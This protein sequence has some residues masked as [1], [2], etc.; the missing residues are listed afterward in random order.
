MRIVSALPPFFL[1]VLCG[2]G[3]GGCGRKGPPLAPLVFLPAPVGELTTKRLGSDA[4]L[5]FTI[6]TTNSD[7][8]NP[9]DLDRIEVYA[10]T[11]P[12]PTPADYV[13]YGTLIARIQIR[14]PRELTGAT[15]AEGAAAANGGV[16]PAATPMPEQ[17][18]VISVVE[19]L[20]EEH[21]VLGPLPFKQT[22]GTAPIVES[23]ETEGTVNLPLPIIRYYAVVG[24]S[25]SRNRRGAFA[26]PLGIPLVDPLAAP[27]DVKASYS[28]TAITLTWPETPGQFNVYDVDASGAQGTGGP[29]GAGGAGGAQG[30]ARIGRPVAP[31]NTA[32]LATPEFADPRLEFGTERCYAVRTVLTVG[33][34]AVESEPSPRVCVRPIDTFA[35]SAPRTLASVSSENVV[36][37]IWEPNIEKDLG[38]YR[39]LRGEGPDA[40]LAPLTPSPIQETTYRD[41]T[42]ESGRTYTYAVEAVDTATPPNVS[43]PSNR[44]TETIR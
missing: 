4:V 11:G 13:R 26:G 32:A 1:C 35:P 20:T 37:L 40:T 3:H 2:L 44:V 42:V 28:E 21:K 18:A 5:Q 39:V 7:L 23:L 17:G 33:A 25:R 16:D 27:E 9:A 6:P 43:E 10:H 24:V 41:E 14:D 15:G 31:L 29:T 36:T 12:L 22:T 19:T 34:T 8:T 38:G 30:A